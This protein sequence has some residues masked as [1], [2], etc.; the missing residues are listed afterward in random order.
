MSQVEKFREDSQNLKS[1][2]KNKDMLIYEKL[3][4]S[5]MRYRRLFETAK[6]GI[7]ILDFNTGNIVDANPFIVKIIGS[8][9]EEILGKKLWEIGLFSNKEESELAFIELKKNSYIR[10]ED[11]P[12]QKQTGKVTEVEFISNVYLANNIKVIQCNIRDITERKQTERKQELTAKILTILNSQNNWKRSINNIL[13]EIKDYTRIE[14]IGIRLKKNED[15]PFYESIGFPEYYSKTENTLCSRNE[16]G[17]IICEGKEDPY[18]KCICDNIISGQTDL[19]LPYFTQGGSFYSNN[20]SIFLAP[21]NDSE[22][23]LGT[24]NRSSTENWES[25][26]LVPLYSGEKIIGLLQMNDKRLDMFSLENIE[27]FEEIGNTIGIAFNRIQNENKIRESE[28][29]LKKQNTD[30]LNLNIRLTESLN[31]IQLINNELITA[32]IK[33]KESDKLK[34]AFMANMSH[35]I[36][37]PMNAIVGFS[38]FLLEPGLNPQKLM[39]FAQI[40]NSSSQQLLSIISDI[41]DISK[42]EADQITIGSE[43]VN[44]NNLLDELFVIYK[45]IV[46]LKGLSLSHCKDRPDEIIQI[47]SDG[48]RIKQI[49]CNLL[50]NAIK[51]TKEGKIEFGY[52]IK[53][54]VIAFYVTDTGIGITPENQELIFERFRQ[55]EQKDSL[56][57]G[58]NGLGLSISRALAEKLEGTITVKS[59]LGS[60]STFTFTIP[61][62]KQIEPN[63]KSVQTPKPGEYNWNEK[64]ILL[65]EDD[66]N[67]HAYI[68]A[69]LNG[70]KVKMV[71]AWDGREAV[72]N[73]KLHSEISLVLM[74]IKLPLINGLEATRL[75]KQIRPQLPVIAQTAYALSRDREDAIEAGCDDYFSK[76]IEKEK[77]MKTINSYLSVV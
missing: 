13:V 26:A 24:C 27:F 11:M 46:K 32:N 38:E 39:D 29:A 43:W 16:K 48:N 37:T 49:I 65:V 75:I 35:E 51:F 3:E 73:V 4:E 7:L 31:R 9:L 28:E 52:K 25:I 2:D 17:E 67:N 40:I 55:I 47:K 57:Y 41:I 6:D 69:L 44:I 76:P 74:D 50:N 72:D 53:E 68:E 33:A 64:T 61:Y 63:I 12:I 34:S 71:H 14:A 54:N 18:V 62:I 56:I 15:F 42:I 5:E 21:T 19:S 20:F 1:S 59:E 36:R 23:Q 45:K 70:T 58:G 77:F 8:P 30:Y 22:K 60:G 66:I 10:F